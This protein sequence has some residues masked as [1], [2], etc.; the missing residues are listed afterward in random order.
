MLNA[1]VFA[2]HNSN[3]IITPQIIRSDR[4]T[5]NVV[6]GGLQRYFR[7]NFED[8]FS[9][10]K[11][12]RYGTS[13]AN[14]RIKARWSIFRRSRSNWWINYCKDLVEEGTFDPSIPY[15]LEAVRFSFMGIL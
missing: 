1:D 12:F 13:T 2:K 9:G 7:R 15:H 6:T 8:S 4:G 10:E 11:I 3:V 14:H 5:E